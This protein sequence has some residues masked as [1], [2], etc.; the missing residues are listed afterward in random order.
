MGRDKRIDELATGVPSSEDLLAMYDMSSPGTKRI[1]VAQ[2]VSLMSAISGSQTIWKTV[3][4]GG[5][6]VY[7]TEIIGRQITLILRGGIGTGKVVDLNTT[8]PTGTQIGFDSITGELQCN[9]S[10]WLPTEELTI[11]YI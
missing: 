6:S 1:T 11:Q 8:I 2:I 4:T 9:S 7:F 5:P 10:P 3:A